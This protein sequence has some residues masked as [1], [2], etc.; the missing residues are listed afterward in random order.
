M[1]KSSTN[2]TDKTIGHGDDPRQPQQETERRAKCRAKTDLFVNRFLNGHPYLC[3]MTD[4]SL[5]GARLVAINEP[6]ITP[7]PAFMGLQFQLPGRREVIIASGETVTSDN[8]RNGCTV[9]VRFTRL[10]ATAVAAIEALAAEPQSK[11]C[12]RLSEP[13][14]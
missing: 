6:R 14:G 3:R 13:G 5:S 9:G 7:A 11:P 8:G 12:S 2:P 4:I 10:P 1:E